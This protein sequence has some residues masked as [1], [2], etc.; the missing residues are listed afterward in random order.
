MR[1]CSILSVILVA[2]L[3]L[4]STSVLN[5]TCIALAQVHFQQQC[6]TTHP[7][8][9]T[10][11]DHTQG[12]CFEYHCT[13]NTWSQIAAN[14]DSKI[15]ATRYSTQFWSLASWRHGLIFPWWIT[16]HLSTLELPCHL[17]DTQS[18]LWGLSGVPHH[19]CGIWLPKGAW[20]HQKI[21]FSLYTWPDRFYSLPHCLHLNKISISQRPVI[22]CDMLLNFPTDSA[23]DLGG[24]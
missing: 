20:L 13:M 2:F 16:V 11:P 23:G 15:S 6:T 4:F 10:L 8:L 9:S 1:T 17:L 24:N 21:Q 12:V 5:C 19:P 18:F 7:V 14:H 3:W 22:S